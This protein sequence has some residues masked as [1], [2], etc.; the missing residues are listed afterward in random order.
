MQLLLRNKNYIYLIIITIIVG[1]FEIF[2]FQKTILHDAIDYYYP[3]RKTIVECIRNGNL[4]TWEFYQELGSPIM[5]NPQSG[6]WYPIVWIISLFSEYNLYVLN[7]EYGFHLI[8]C[9]IGS[10]LFFYQFS[11]NKITSYIGAILYTFSGFIIGNFQHL[12]WLISASWMPFVFLSYIYLI[13]RNHFK[14]YLYTAL[15]SYMLLSGGYAAFVILSIYVLII[16]TI[17]EWFLHSGKRIKIIKKIF[18]TLIIT[19]SVSWLYVYSVLLNIN[20]ITRGSGLELNRA[21]KNPFEI[22]NWTSFLFSFSSTQKMSFFHSDIA[23]RN[24]Y[25]GI[26]FIIILLYVLIF[27]RTKKNVLLISLALL[28]LLIAIGKSFYLYPLIYKIVPGISLFKEISLF[29]YFAILILILIIVKNANHLIE[30]KN[31]KKSFFIIVFILSI[32]GSLY[33][34]FYANTEVFYKCILRQLKYQIIILILFSSIILVVQNEKLKMGIFCFLIISEI[35]YSERLNFPYTVLRENEL[36]KLQA[37]YTKIEKEKPTTSNITNHKKPIE[38]AY[39]EM[40]YQ[41]NLLTLGILKKVPSIEGETSFQLK[42]W[43]KYKKDTNQLKSLI[44]KPLAYLKNQTTANLVIKQKG[45]KLIIKTTTTKKNKL[46]IHQNLIPGW[47]VTV[48]DKLSKIQR[49]NHIFVSIPI[50]KGVNTIT[51]KYLP[52]GVVISFISSLILF[53]TSI[54]YLLYFEFN[55]H[56]KNGY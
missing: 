13:Q 5:S 8:L 2:S 54:V 10:Y 20:N 28:F 31:R 32:L 16:Y 41:P 33:F 29:R 48:N 51:L 53:L 42:Q 55:E 25:I 14:Y 30:T 44:N 9:G 1:Y 39:K 56:R 21:T 19:L 7:I 36:S 45:N 12:S 43:A 22:S 52:N 27:L 3:W 38:F 18:Y 37:I 49:F 15:F 24:G 17:Y 35:I 26:F 6:A 40:R 4:P 46:I 50:N 47:I 11:K 34:I 23:M